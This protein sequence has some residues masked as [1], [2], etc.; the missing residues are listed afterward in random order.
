MQAVPESR[1]QT[2]EE[3][4]GPPENFLEIEV[5]QIRVLN[6][7]LPPYQFA[8]YQSNIRAPSNKHLLILS[9]SK[10]SNPWNLPEHVHFI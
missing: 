9:G 7:L 6:P 5:S 8:C 2:F 4:Y 1:Q 3:I 10:S